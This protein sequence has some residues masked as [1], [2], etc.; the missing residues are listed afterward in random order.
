MTIIAGGG[1]PAGFELLKEANSPYKAGIFWDMA[2]QGWAAMDALNR[3]FQGQPQVYEGVGFRLLT[4]NH[5]TSASPDG[6]QSPIDFQAAYT[7]IWRG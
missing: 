2:W 7:K 3:Y 1:T 4:A 5:V 6:Y